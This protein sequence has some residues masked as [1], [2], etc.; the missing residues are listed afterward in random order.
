MENLKNRQIFGLHI[1]P[2]IQK[3]RCNENINRLLIYIESNYLQELE[4]VNL[5]LRLIRHTD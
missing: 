1:D 4:F 3:I 2:V 5:S